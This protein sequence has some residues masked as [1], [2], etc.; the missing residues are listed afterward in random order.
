MCMYICIYI[1]SYIEFYVYSTLP[2]VTRVYPVQPTGEG[3]R[4]LDLLDSF[5]GSNCRNVGIPYH[6]MLYCQHRFI[7]MQ[8]STE[9]II[10]NNHNV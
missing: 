7:N 9:I 2:H 10:A 4:M 5:G 3:P 6:C 1:C 8:L